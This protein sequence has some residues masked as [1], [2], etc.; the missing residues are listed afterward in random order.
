MSL[1]SLQRFS[2]VPHT[3]AFLRIGSSEHSGIRGIEHDGMEGAFVLCQAEGLRG[4]GAAYI[5]NQDSAVVAGASKDVVIVRMNG[6][7]VDRFLV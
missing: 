6:K 4:A 5:V 1:Y 3:D 2:H 7:P